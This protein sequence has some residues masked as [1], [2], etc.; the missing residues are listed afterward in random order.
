M[1]I[2][3]TFRQ[4]CEFIRKDEPTLIDSVDRILCLAIVCS[5]V[6]LGPGALPLLGLLPAKNELTKIGKD[7]F[8]KFVGK[9][10]SDFLAH[11]ER[12]E[13]AYGLICFTS[14]FEAVDR[15]LPTPLRKRIELLPEDRRC[16]S[17]KAIRVLEAK[18]SA[19][20]IRSGAAGMTNVPAISVP[21]P[22]PIEAFGDQRERLSQLYGQMVG[23]LSELLEKLAMWED[24]SDGEK[25]AIQEALRRAPEIALDCF[26]AQYFELANAYSDFGIWANLQRHEETKK[27]L[28]QLSR[29]VQQVKRSASA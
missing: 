9:K 1:S 14:F 18:A 11:Q 16:I 21:F 13:Q 17:D 25:T 5:P 7:I 28:S 20:R 4:V 15:V 2:D 6:V 24:L 23:R 26:D 19:T 8:A 12:M 10:D 29:S 27:L 3:L 22:H